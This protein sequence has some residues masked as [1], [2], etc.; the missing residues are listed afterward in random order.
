MQILDILLYLILFPLI[1]AL[2]LLFERRDSSRT[3]IVQLSAV[4]IGIVS[5]LLLVLGFDKGS[6]IYA[7]GSEPVSQ[8]M[9]FIEM[10]LAVFILWLGIR[11]R[12]SLAVVL[13]LLQAGLLVWFETSLAGNL[14]VENNLFVDQFS[15]IMAL[16]IGIIGTLICVYAVGYMETYHNHHKEIRDRRNIFFG[17]LFLFLAAMCANLK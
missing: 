4:A 10:V 8:A 3:L 2:F 1:A 14:H 6:L 13:I 16:I 9:F 15:I 11:Y 7:V 12:K 5:L 17:I